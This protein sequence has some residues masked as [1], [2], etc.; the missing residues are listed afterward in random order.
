MHMSTRSGEGLHA[1]LAFG[2]AESRAVSDSNSAT[3]M[4]DLGPSPERCFWQTLP[5]LSLVPAACRAE[6]TAD[7]FTAEYCPHEQMGLVRLQPER[8]IPHSSRSGSSGVGA[9]ASCSFVS[10]GADGESGSLSMK[11]AEAEVAA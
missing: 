7:A 9:G 6:A 3:K 10:A 4:R 5:W 8:Q 2:C 11:A 1:N